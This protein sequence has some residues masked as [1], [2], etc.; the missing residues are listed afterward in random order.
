MLIY[1]VLPRLLLWLAC[2]WRWRRGCAALT[3]DV[4]LPGHNL[5]RE[6]LQPDSERLGVCDAAPAHL[7]QPLA[8]S[9]TLDSQGALLVA[10]ELDQ[11]RPWPP[12]LPKGVSDAGVLDSR[13]QRKQLL[14]QLSRFPPE[15]LLIACDPRRSPDRGT[16]ALLGELARSAAAT[17][18]WLLQAP[19][20]EALDSE[21]L[22]DWHQALD[23]LQLSHS[24]CA[25]MSWLESGHD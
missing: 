11:S 17:R 23:R 14:D 2:L 19:P 21:R 8:G 15:R 1:G 22:G 24:D 16:L 25:P 12:T 20:G 13:E 7:H 9:H 10:V 4:R 5:L 3:L 6:R 18:I